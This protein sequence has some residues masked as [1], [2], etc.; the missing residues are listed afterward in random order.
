M[1]ALTNNMRKI[2]LFNPLQQRLQQVID[3]LF[4]RK[5]YDANV[6]LEA[7]SEQIRDA[8]DAK[9]IEKYVLDTVKNTIHPETINSW[10]VD[11]S[12]KS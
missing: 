3:R 11:Q 9:A 10:V 1:T 7:F 12:S 4:Y 6:T 8:I 5:R 2:A